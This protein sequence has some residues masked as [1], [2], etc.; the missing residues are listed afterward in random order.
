MSK[1]TESTGEASMPAKPTKQPI[2]L[3]AA[4]QR[5]AKALEADNKSLRRRRGKFFVV[6]LAKNVVTHTDAD[7]EELGQELGVIEL[8]EEVVDDD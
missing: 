2:S 7:L 5:I 6:D 1:Q 3:R 4:K 8:W